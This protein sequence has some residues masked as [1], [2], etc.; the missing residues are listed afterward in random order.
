MKRSSIVKLA[1]LVA[2]VVFIIIS[3]WLAYSHG[4][5]IARNFA[6]FSLDML[7]IIPG[8]F[9]LIGLFDVWVKKETVEK[10]LGEGSGF[11]GYVWVILLAGA[12]VG[13]LYVA[14]PVAY[15][16]YSKG[17]RLSVIFTYVGAAAVCRIPMT[18]FEASFLGISFSIIRLAVSLIL[19]IISAMLF[20][21]YL[22]KRNY[23]ISDGTR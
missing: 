6:S 4:E 19:V 1:G 23:K 18:I 9:I 21:N 5:E 13:G 16:M 3:L 11:R 2:Y 20:G 8:A 10:H 7:K 15:S 14:F 22:K 17:A 12:T